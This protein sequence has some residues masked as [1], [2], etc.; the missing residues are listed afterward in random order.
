MIGDRPPFRRDRRRPTLL[1]LTLAAAAG[2]GLLLLA[3]SGPVA[4]EV[5]EVTARRND[6]SDKPFVFDP[7]LVEVRAGSTVRWQN[8]SQTFHTVTFSPSTG[9]R[10]ADGTFEE[11]MFEVGDEIVR[12]FPEPGRF[13]FFCQPH[14][15]FMIGEVLVVPP[16]EPTGQR[17]AGLALVSLAIGGT[18]VAVAGPVLV[19]ALARDR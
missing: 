15:E 2:L 4:P 10:V 11:S 8:G 18:A 6:E 13:P 9:E 7:D 19:D 17:I 14:A 5:V 16:P 3:G 1:L 12:T